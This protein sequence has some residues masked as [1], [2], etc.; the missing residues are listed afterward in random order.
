MA[1]FSKGERVR[2]VTAVPE[3]PVSR[4]RMDDDGNVQYLITWV[5]L[6]GEEQHKWFDEAELE[7][8]AGVSA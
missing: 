7:P 4:M 1:K 3:G 6:R 2:L 5:D 8:V